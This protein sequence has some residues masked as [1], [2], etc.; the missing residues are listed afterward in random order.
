MN[1]PPFFAVQ[2]QTVGDITTLVAA[3]YT[4]DQIDFNP[5][6]HLELYVD[7]LQIPGKE[8]ILKGKNITIY[9]HVI[10]CDAGAILNVTA[11][12]DNTMVMPYSN[13]K[14]NSGESSGQSGTDGQDGGITSETTAKTGN[15]AGNITIN[16]GAINGRLILKANGGKGQQAQTGQDGGD[17]R[18]GGNGTDAIIR[19]VVHDRRNPDTYD[20]TPATGGQSG[21]NAGKG[22]NSGRSGNGGNGG[23]INVNVFVALGDDQITHNNVGGSAGD[24]ATAGKAGRNGKGG[25]GGRIA[26]QTTTQDHFHREIWELSDD[27]TD[28]GADGNTGVDGNTTAATAGNAGAYAGARSDDETNLLVQNTSMLAL[29]L[30]SMRYAEAEYLQGNLA[31]ALDYYQWIARL[32]AKATDTASLAREFHGIYR[33]CRALMDQLRQGLDYYANPMNYVPIVSLDYYQL[34]ID[35]ML[36]TGNAIESVYNQYYAFISGQTHDFTN[37][38]QATNSAAEVLT[39][40]KNIQANLKTQITDLPPVINTLST[41]LDNQYQV[42]IKASDTFKKAVEDQQKCSFNTLL[43][44]I[45]TIV[46]VGKDTLDAFTNP[47]I[48]SIT[49]AKGDWEKLIDSID[50]GKIVLNPEA[51][52]G[53]AKS[54]EDAWQKISPGGG[55]VEDSTKLVAMRDEFDKTITPYLTL[56]QAKEYQKQLHDYIGIAQARNVKL[57]EYTNMA[58]QYLAIVAKIEQKQEELDRIKAQIASENVPGLITYRSF[59]Y[60]L[61]QDFKSFVLKYIYQE[62]RAFIYW[63]QQ[64][65]KLNITDD[66]F[67]GLGLAH[68]K[69]K[70]DI[71][72]KINTYSDPKQQLTDVMIKL[73]PDARQEQFQKFKTDRTITF[74]IPTDDVNFLGWSNVMLTNFRIYINGAKMASNDK[75]YVQLLHQGHVLIVDPAGKVKDFSHNRVSSVYQYDIVDGKT[76]TVAGGSLGGD[77]TGDNSKRIPLSPFATFTVNVPDRFNPEANLDNIDSIEIHF[78]GYASP[79]KGFRKKRALAQ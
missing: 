48:D 54:I 29:L 79:T 50:T 53:D 41:A 1:T 9:A 8:F 46:A 61:Y 3:N 75:L 10:N 26:I 39:T 14:A 17:G 5:T 59:I 18:D 74:N 47:S 31:P 60:A 49:T 28:S 68:S 44:L 66:S 42:L 13:P 7:R 67:T 65:N 62:N 71:I 51:I 35:G 24:T 15:N 12:D 34:M 56:P 37:M 70:G 58:I 78:A 77:T 23:A 2:K 33:Q 40:Y 11:D 64:D 69:L 55:D 19:R 38:T 27:R 25:I 57:F 63:A 32:T 21:G 73:L 16:A 72:T 4:L 76:H 30:L 22:G 45:K 6:T 20:V 36:Q 52:Q 43:N